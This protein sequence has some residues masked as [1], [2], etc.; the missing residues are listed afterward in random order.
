MSRS[1]DDNGEGAGPAWMR[2]AWFSLT[3]REQRAVL[4]FLAL[5]LLGVIARWRYVF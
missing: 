4:L 2:R 3:L 5:F 1:P